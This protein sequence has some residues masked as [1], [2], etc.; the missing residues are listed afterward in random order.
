VETLTSRMAE[1]AE[2]KRPIAEQP[3]WHPI[4]MLATIARHIDGMVEAD[5]EQLATLQE[6]RTKPY[7]LDD[8][9]VNHVEHAFTTRRE[10][11]W[12]IEEQ[13][14]S[15]QAVQLTAKPLAFAK[16]TVTCSP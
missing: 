10:D 6:A 9:T 11:F 13:L 14:R 15:F 3:H 1:K 5:Q 4:A 16:S 2:K 12:V 8:S 7:I